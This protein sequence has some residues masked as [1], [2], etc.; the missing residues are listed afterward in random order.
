VILLSCSSEVDYCRSCIYICNYH[1]QETEFFRKLATAGVT[2]SSIEAMAVFSPL[3]LAKV[4]KCIPES[5][6]GKGGNPQWYEI[7]ISKQ[8]SCYLC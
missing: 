8:N 1:L 2:V 6:D 5:L 4:G 7:L 3:S